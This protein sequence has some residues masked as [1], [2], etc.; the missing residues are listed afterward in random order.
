[1]APVSNE[2]IYKGVFPEI[3]GSSWNLNPRVIE[4]LINM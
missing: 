2:P 3:L 1:M 4:E